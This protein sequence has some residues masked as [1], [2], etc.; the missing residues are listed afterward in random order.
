LGGRGGEAGGDRGKHV[1][2]MVVIEI[3]RIA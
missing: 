3:L 2:F 1:C